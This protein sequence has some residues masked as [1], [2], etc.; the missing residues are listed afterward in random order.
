[1]M[2]KNKNQAIFDHNL[3]ENHDILRKIGY[4]KKN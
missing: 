3:I 4:K 2:T 1:M